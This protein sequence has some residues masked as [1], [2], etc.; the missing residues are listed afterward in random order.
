MNLDFGMRV[1]LEPFDED[2]VDRAH[3][4]EQ[5]VERWFG[6]TAQLAQQGP[7]MRRCNHDLLRPRLTMPPGIL[8][9][10]IDVECMM[11]MLDC[12]YGDAA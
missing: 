9:R 4:F 3:P 12:R 8:T 7:T 10:L 5:L 11:G 2:Q 1:P 6:R